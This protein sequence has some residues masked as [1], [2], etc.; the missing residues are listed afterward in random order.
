MMVKCEKCKSECVSCE[1]FKAWGMIV[2]S[3]CYR[4]LTK[5]NTRVIDP[6]R[7]PSLAEQA[8]LEIEESQVYVPKYKKQW[9]YS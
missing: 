9:H 2:C 6:D 1:T 5:D 8:K 3:S 4:K 7:L